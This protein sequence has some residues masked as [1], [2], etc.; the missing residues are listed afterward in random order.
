MTELCAMAM[1]DRQDYILTQ[2]FLVHEKS[3]NSIT[4]A[5]HYTPE[6]TSTLVTKENERERE[7][8]N[9]YPGYTRERITYIA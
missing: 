6:G 1:M 9:R 3:R 5:A 8:R 2:S 4:Y 7:E